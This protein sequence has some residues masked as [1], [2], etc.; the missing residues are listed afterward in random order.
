M[1]IMSTSAEEVSIQAVSPELMSVN[2]MTVG[3]VGAAGAAVAAAGGG[4]GSGDAA[5]GRHGRSFIRQRPNRVCAHNEHQHQSGE[6]CR[7]RSCLGASVLPSFQINAHNLQLPF[8]LNCQVA[9]AAAVPAS[10]L[11]HLRRCSTY[12]TQ[13]DEWSC[14]GA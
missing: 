3:S 2:F 6:R 12:R 8:F 1:V 5:G 9:V 13:P 11:A 10:R 7:H 14:A 4:G